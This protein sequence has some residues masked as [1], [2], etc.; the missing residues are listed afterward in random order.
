MKDSGLKRFG[1]LLAMISMLILLIQSCVHEP[2]VPKDT[3][4]TPEPPPATEDQCDENVVYFQNEILPILISNCAK[5]GCHD[6]ATAKD[7]IILNSYTNVMNSDD[8]ITPFDVEDSE[9]YEKITED[10]H[11]DVMPP[12]PN[13][14]LSSAQ[15]GLIRT[16]IEQGAKNN[17]CAST[18]CD[19]TQV[20]FANSVMPLLT[21]KCIGCHSGNTPSGNLNFTSHQVVQTVGQDGRLIGAVTHA[22]GFTPMPQG[23]SKLSECEISTLRIWIDQGA[24]N[25]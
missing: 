21:N 14:P 23:G 19:T 11:D 9:L 17:A 10:D 18:A 25:N 3:T 20:T 1:H 5:S 7:G 22:A 16:W 8:V 6:A 4:T 13:Q 15:I 24:P 12:P 2:L